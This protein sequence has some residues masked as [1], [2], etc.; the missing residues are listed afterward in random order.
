MLCAADVLNVVISYIMSK[1]EFQNV[2]TT[3]LGVFKRKKSS[4][5]T[6]KYL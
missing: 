5:V 6:Q 4:D 3:D 2:L 1:F